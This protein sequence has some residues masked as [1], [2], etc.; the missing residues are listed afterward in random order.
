MATSEQTNAVG[1]SSRYSGVKPR[2][3]EVALGLFTE[4]GVDGTTLQMIADELGVTK[5]AVYHQF[6]TKDEIVLAGAEASLARLEVVLDG[7]D[8]AADPLDHLLSGL[9]DLSIDQRRMINLLQNDPVMSRL[10][11]Q[12]ER[13]G[14][15][16]QRLFR[17][18]TQNLSRGDSRVPVAIVMAAIGGAVTSPLL[19]E[20]D[21][22]ELRRGLLDLARRLLGPDE[23]RS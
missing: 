20:G 17:G 9:I 2:T 19:D 18:L 16:T 12:H 23:L 6:R 8:D 7:A 4:Y 14:Q 22:D 1:S 21:H 3:I 10:L 13:Y 11:G 15:L 5:A